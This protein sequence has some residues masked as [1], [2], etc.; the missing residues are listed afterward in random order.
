MKLGVLS[1]THNNLTALEQALALFRQEKVD[2]LIH[3]GDVTTPETASAMGEFPVWHAVGNG[4]FAS[5]EI[6][7]IL[8]GFN[9][10]NQSALVVTGVLGGISIAVTHGHLPGK[11]TELVQSGQ[12]AY[13]FYGHSHRRKAQK[14]GNTWLINPG[15]LGGLRPEAPSVYLIDLESGD[16][17][18]FLVPGS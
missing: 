11:V 10:L 4:D 12:Y 5:G 17:G 6:R 2:W 3:C 8:Q 7:A 9:P 14:V 15:A 18:F 16:G 13:V 1:D